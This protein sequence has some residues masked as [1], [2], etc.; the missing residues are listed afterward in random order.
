MIFQLLGFRGITE[1]R[2]QLLKSVSYVCLSLAKA[3]LANPREHGFRHGVL[4]FYIFIWRAS[5]VTCH[6]MCVEIRGQLAKSLF[7]LSTVWVSGIELMTIG[8]GNKSLS[9]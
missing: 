7:T 9:R 8:L 4:C 2:R 6:S 5:V 1:P 3:I